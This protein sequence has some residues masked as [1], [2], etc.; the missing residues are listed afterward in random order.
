M[1]RHRGTTLS[2]PSSIAK[3]PCPSTSYER[4]NPLD[5]PYEKGRMTIELPEWE[6]RERHRKGAALK[7]A[8]QGKSDAICGQKFVVATVRGSL[9]LGDLG[10]LFVAMT[11]GLA[12]LLEFVK[13]HLLFPGIN[14]ILLAWPLLSTNLFA[15]NTPRKAEEGVFLPEPSAETLYTFISRRTNGPHDPA[16]DGFQ[17]P[18]S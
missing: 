16:K 10:T 3:G 4:R 18:R 6:D 14:D 17:I 7:Q 2:F 15:K 13:P 9:C 1:P 8:E 12:P 5:N 11:W